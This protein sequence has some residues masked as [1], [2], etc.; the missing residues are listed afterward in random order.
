[1]RSQRVLLVF[2][3]LF[4]MGVGIGIDRFA[5]QHGIVDAAN[6]F[7]N[8]EF[9][10]LS[11]TYDVIRD[12]YVESD[13][14]SDEELAWGAANGMVE[15][16]GDE[17]HSVFLNPDEAEQY[18]LSQNGELIGIGVTLD[19]T[20]GV[21][22]VI[23]PMEGSP[24]FDAGIRSGDIIIEVD[25]QT[26]QGYSETEVPEVTTSLIRGEEGTDVTLTLIR[27]SDG[28]EYE[29]TITR[30]RI[31]IVPVTWT[32]LPNNVMWLRLSQ[33]SSGATEEVIAALREGKEAGAEALILDLRGNGG[34]LV[35]E[36]IGIASQFLTNNTTLYIQRDKDGDENPV[37]SVGNNGEWLE[38]PMVV[39]AD[40]TSASAA[41]IT[42]SALAVAGRAEVLGTTTYG[43]GTVL[44]PFE[45]KDG[46]LAV[47]G[48]QLWL[49]ADG[50]Q[51]WKIGVAPTIEVPLDEEATVDL[52]TLHEGAEI[53]ESE[54]ESM[55]DNQLIAGYDQAIEE[56]GAP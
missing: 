24:A 28:K 6:G 49:T 12:N 31:E 3:M 14:I 18:V 46:S 32:M 17:N 21:V 20:G 23:Q 10:I 30:T 8:D 38:A 41:E 48:T 13:E 33:F 56:L 51:I 29:V 52:P 11:E 7:E 22:T 43:T 35:F 34:G 19:F 40:G 26:L 54:L 4:S 25:G 9:D 47:I 45:L 36:M 44:L 2:M 55:T 50:E 53:S 39:L 1:M 42:A 27:K 37:K 5:V 15:A 16:L